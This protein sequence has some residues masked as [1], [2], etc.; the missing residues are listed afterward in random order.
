MNKLLLDV[1]ALRVESFHTADCRPARGT[2]LG[3][4]GGTTIA[5]YCISFTCGDSQIR[6]CMDAD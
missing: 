3:A 1:D 6:P 5:P 4:D 2:V